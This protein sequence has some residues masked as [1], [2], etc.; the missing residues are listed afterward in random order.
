ME[1]ERK[2]VFQAAE[3]ILLIMKYEG[4]IEDL[5]EYPSEFEDAYQEL[6]KYKVIKSGEGK[7]LPGENFKRAYELG[8]KNY[9]YKINNPS[10][11]QKMVKTKPVIGLLAG[12]L[13][14]TAGYLYK[15][16]KRV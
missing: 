8:F 13:L 11:L 14:V 1:Q 2:D 15:S 6:L 3:V 12:A 9:L 5:I 4:E 16:G 10:G 7:Y